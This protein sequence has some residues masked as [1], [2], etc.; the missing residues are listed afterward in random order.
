MRVRALAFVALALLPL[1]ASCAGDSVD[2]KDDADQEVTT[3]SGLHRR[4][5]ILRQH[6][7]QWAQFRRTSYQIP[8]AFIDLDSAVRIQSPK[9]EDAVILPCVGA[10]LAELAAAGYFIALVSNEPEIG[11]KVLTVQGADASAFSAVQAILKQG[12]VIDYY[13]F[14]EGDDDA[15]MPKTVL[16]DRLERFLANYNHAYRIDRHRSFVVG[17]NAVARQFALNYLGQS[18]PWLPHY[19]EPSYFFGWRR[20]GAFSTPAEVKK[21]EA[22]PDA[23]CEVKQNCEGMPQPKGKVPYTPPVY[24]YPVKD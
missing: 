15:V 17:A 20:A 4:S 14:A 5:L 23:C 11:K 3:K 7:T 10:R 8:V 9:P 1:L 18:T 6:G 13:D 2:E 22:L 24:D 21:Y 16:A 19:F 12:G